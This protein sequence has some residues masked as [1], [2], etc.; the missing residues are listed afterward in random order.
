MC[1]IG[2]HVERRAMGCPDE[3]DFC[4]I[5]QSHVSGQKLTL[6]GLPANERLTAFNTVSAAGKVALAAK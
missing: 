5:M 1:R 4:Y 2:L 3:R 6:T